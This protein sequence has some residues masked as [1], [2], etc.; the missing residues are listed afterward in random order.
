[1]NVNRNN[2]EE[3]C[4]LY[5]DNE[6]SN[7]ERLE[8]EAF[9]VENPDLAVELE[10]LQQL[11][12]GLP[13]EAPMLEDK[14]MLLRSSAFERKSINAENYETYF[15]LY[16][17]GELNEQGRSDTEQ[18]L[19]EHP[20]L[21]RE[22]LA[23]RA[24]RLAAEPVSFP[25]KSLLYKRTTQPARITVMRWW[26]VAAA[27]AVI[28]GAVWIGFNAGSR[29]GAD[30]PVA[31]ISKKSNAG[32]ADKTVVPSNNNIQPAENKNADPVASPSGQQLKE[33]KENT[34]A[35]L[36][37]TALNKNHATQKQQV[38]QAGKESKPE[39]EPEEPR[40]AM[41]EPEKSNHLPSRETT[42]GV[43][44]NPT[45]NTENEKHTVAMNENADIIDKPL[46]GPNAGNV[47]NDFASEALLSASDNN[48][49][50]TAGYLEEDDHKS[51]LRGVFR[52]ASRVLNRITS[53]D[54]FKPGSKQNK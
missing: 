33:V 26:R 41:V 46:G 17:D 31:Q 16:T 1:M 4:L 13:D 6:L 20:E 43:T 51:P 9:V 50:S 10:L 52:K 35:I 44:E 11:K 7:E 3:F 18:F 34:E 47:K 24:T 14:S 23:L 49:P 12:L 38:V 36:A 54:V 53:P 39:K 37:G 8:L 28:L 15:L 42:T 19:A 29:S 21:Q 45:L 25:D 5:L 48:K 40:V 27:A 2:F 32:K 30:Q 22:F